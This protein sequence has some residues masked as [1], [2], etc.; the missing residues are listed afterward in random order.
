MI[1]ALF[2]QVAHVAAVAQNVSEADA[3]AEEVSIMARQLLA[4]MR[5]HPMRNLDAYEPD[6]QLDDTILRGRPVAVTCHF[7]NQYSSA[8]RTCPDLCLLI[9]LIPLLVS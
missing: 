8:L 4:A 3:R 1:N 5:R 6:P 2:P 9:V 7:R